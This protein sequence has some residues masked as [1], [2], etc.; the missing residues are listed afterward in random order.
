MAQECDI[1]LVSVDVVSVLLIEVYIC[2]LIFVLSKNIL[3]TFDTTVDIDKRH[4]LRLS[5]VIP[6]T[7]LDAPLGDENVFKADH[8]HR[9]GVCR[10]INLE[11]VDPEHA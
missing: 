10:I 1:A 8:L 6:V 2:R 9:Y 7:I 11:L 3:T 5:H 4:N